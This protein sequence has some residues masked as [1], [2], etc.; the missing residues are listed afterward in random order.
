M[1]KQ[2]S[3]NGKTTS[4]GDHDT[5]EQAARAFDR[6]TINKSGAAAKTNFSLTDYKDEIA[7]LRGGLIIPQ[8]TLMSSD[9]PGD[10]VCFF[11]SLMVQG[12]GEVT[13]ARECFKQLASDNLLGLQQCRNRRW[14]PC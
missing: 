1:H 7:D 3:A 13:S 6:A 5:E 9:L 4:L 11:Q 8:C 12:S 14:W 10:R 2:I